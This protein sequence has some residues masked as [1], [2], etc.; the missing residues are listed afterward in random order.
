MS[1]LSLPSGWPW[2]IALRYVHNIQKPCKECL[3]ASLS[4]NLE[5]ADGSSSK[6]TAWLH[7]S[8][9]IAAGPKVKDPICGDSNT[10]T[11]FSSGNERS[12]VKYAVHEQGI[13]AGYRLREEVGL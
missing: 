11:I 13:D 4:A 5:Y 7:H 3:I 8:V 2:L 9:L 10:E 6:G 12:T 1:R